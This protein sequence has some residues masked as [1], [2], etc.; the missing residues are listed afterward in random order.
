M[1]NTY[2]SKK[3]KLKYLWE[4]NEIQE[5]KISNKEKLSLDWN[6]TNFNK[7]A[8]V[9]LIEIEPRSTTD[10]RL[11]VYETEITLYNFPD[12]LVPFLKFN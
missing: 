6:A 7:K 12:E 11:L 4:A 10:T 8:G 5:W 2:S 3:Q 9:Y 1:E